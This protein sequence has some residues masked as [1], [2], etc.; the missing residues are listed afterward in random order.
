MIYLLNLIGLAHRARKTVI[1][2]DFS[3]KSIQKKEAK[4]VFLAND[5]G[6]NTTKK[7]TDKCG[8][9]NITLIKDFNTDELSNAI[10]NKNRKVVTIT[11]V[12][13]ANKMKERM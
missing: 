7:I 13:F 2:E 10:G 6:I 9:Y 11:D 4:L 8:F 5:A 3:V 1:G 12:G